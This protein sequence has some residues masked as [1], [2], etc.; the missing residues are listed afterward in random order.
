VR[1]AG[2]HGIVSSDEIERLTI[3]FA[4]GA[5]EDLDFVYV[6]PPIDAGF[7]AYTVPT[8]RQ[9]GPGQLRR[10]VGRNGA[11]EVVSS[12]VL[13]FPPRRIS[14]RP[15]TPRDP[16][17]PR[18]RARPSPLPSAPIQRGEAHGV[19]ISAGR[20][21][22]VLFDLRGVT[23]ERRAM[24]ENGL[25]YA[26][27]KLVVRGGVARDRGL[28]YSGNLQPTAGFRF[29]L[30]GAPLDGCYLNGRY[31]HRWPDR[32]DSHDVVEIPFTEAG[33]RYFED[34]AAASD[35]ALFATSR[36]MLRLRQHPP[37][38][39]AG[40]LR[41]QFGARIAALASRAALPPRGMI[42]YWVDGPN[43]LLRRVSSTGQRLEV[44]IGPN[45]GVHSENIRHLARIV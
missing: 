4:D 38:V 41:T 26:C 5:S 19:L 1:I 23:P 44:V 24:L 35:L 8:E 14:Q 18:Y 7:F 28:G 31:G 15:P 36:A 32:L 42:G 25:I 16:S 12:Q 45:G 6:S 20:N 21:G 2:V 34:R 40:E 27:F 22:S 37:P 29:H 43:V 13:E 17:E 39:T 30:I 33:R 10:I 3:E 11:G 9:S